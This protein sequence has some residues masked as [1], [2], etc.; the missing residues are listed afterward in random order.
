[1]IPV[2]VTLPKLI[3]YCIYSATTTRSHT[4]DAMSLVITTAVKQ[5]IEEARLGPVMKYIYLG[6]ASTGEGRPKQAPRSE[7]TPTTKYGTDFAD[8]AT[9][10][11]SP[12]R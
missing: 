7:P 9:S 11:E 6:R 1:M 5:T 12:T 3:Q 10:A 8:S 4:L 2:G